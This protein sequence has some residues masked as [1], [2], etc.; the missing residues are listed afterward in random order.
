MKIIGPDGEY[1]V[2]W[3]KPDP[4]PLTPE[5]QAVLDAAEAERSAEIDKDADHSDIAAWFRYVACRDL[6]RI[7][8]DT[9]RAAA[10]RGGETDG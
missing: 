2:P 7:A 10:R 6:R 3:A 5:D 9:R 8:V 4:I 1:E